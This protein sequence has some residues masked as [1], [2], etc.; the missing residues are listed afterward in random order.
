MSDGK[1]VEGNLDTYRVMRQNDTSLPGVLNV[2]FE[3]LSGHERFSEIGE[4]P[5]G[6]APAALAHAVFKL[7]GIWMRQMPFSKT[8]L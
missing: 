6:P 4:P 8:V 1:I 2:H 7:T 5:V 3:G